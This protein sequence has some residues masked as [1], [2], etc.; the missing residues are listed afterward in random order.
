MARRLRSGYTTGACAAAAA[1]AAVLC[2][3]TEISQ[4][5]VEIP[6][7]DGSRVWFA[8]HRS[9]FNR[10]A[11]ERVK[12]SASV[13]KDAGDDP[14]VTNGAE[15]VAHSRFVKNNIVPGRCIIL[16]EQR[17]MRLCPGEGVGMVTKPGLAVKQGNR[18]LILCRGR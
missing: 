14:D 6:F 11:D 18:R 13:I 3:L 7:P 12:S 16:D 5:K 1:K 9:S 4:E 17:R 15:I 8:V 2:L 10:S